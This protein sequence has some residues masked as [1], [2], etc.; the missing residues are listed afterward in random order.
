M[1][2]ILPGLCL[3]VCFQSDDTDSDA[4]SDGVVSLHYTES[5]ERSLMSYVD[6][7]YSAYRDLQW[8]IGGLRR[9]LCQIVNC[10][11]S[12]LYVCFL[13]VAW[14]FFIQHIGRLTL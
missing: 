8:V 3:C 2:L 9:T 13:R 5:G 6:E 12:K 4:A 1:P 10:Y 14:L 11:D 7:T